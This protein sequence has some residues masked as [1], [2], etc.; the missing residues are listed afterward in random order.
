VAGM[1]TI[2]GRECVEIKTG[3]SQYIKDKKIKLAYKYPE[4]RPLV[5]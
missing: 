5:S 1:I 4:E 2:K 3:L